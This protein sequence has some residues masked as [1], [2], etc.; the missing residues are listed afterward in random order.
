M[1][2]DCVAITVGDAAITV[3]DIAISVASERIVLSTGVCVG[4]DSLIRLTH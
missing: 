1:A 3:G 4:I 2:A